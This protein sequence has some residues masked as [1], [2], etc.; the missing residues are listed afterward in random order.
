[1]AFSSRTGSSLILAKNSSA[2]LL[3]R[4]AYLYLVVN[5]CRTEISDA[6]RYFGSPLDQVRL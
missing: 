5:V 3:N 4:Q 1:M 6:Q 2:Y